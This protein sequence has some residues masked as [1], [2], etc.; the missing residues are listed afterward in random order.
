MSGLR[1]LQVEQQSGD[2][3]E[4]QAGP[5]TP[6]LPNYILIFDVYLCGAYI[7]YQDLHPHLPTSNKGATRTQSCRYLPIPSILSSNCIN[8]Y[9]SLSVS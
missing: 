7:L 8:L 6:Q 3:E 4:C 9:L 1:D 2:N 5:A